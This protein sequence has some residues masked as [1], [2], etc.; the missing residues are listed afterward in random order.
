MLKG[1]R[2]LSLCSSSS[3]HCFCGSDSF[4][5]SKRRAVLRV[6]RRPLT[7]LLR[8][9][10]HP[11]RMGWGQPT[12]HQQRP[13]KEVTT[14]TPVKESGRRVVRL[15][16][17][18]SIILL[19]GVGRGGYGGERW[20]MGNGKWRKAGDNR[21]SFEKPLTLILSPKGRGDRQEEDSAQANGKAPTSRSTPKAAW[22]GGTALAR[23]RSARPSGHLRC[24]VLPLPAAR[25]SIKHVF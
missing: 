4:M 20:E 12:L 25:L 1:C 8:R 17:R 19:D 7:D 18:K 16:Y 10:S 3:S 14:A 22:Q 24:C 6:S 5:I 2:F 9:L 21:C 23:A 11:S 15:G 13:A